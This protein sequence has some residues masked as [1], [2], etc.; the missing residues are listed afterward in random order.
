MSGQRDRKPFYTGT[1][2]R[3]FSAALGLLLAATGV[4]AMLF[5]E[6]PVLPR[7]A[8]GAAFLLLGGNL[9]LAAYQARESWLSRIGPLP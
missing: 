5:S 2:Y 7:A 9:L 8:I 6:A 3:L 1:F 4:W